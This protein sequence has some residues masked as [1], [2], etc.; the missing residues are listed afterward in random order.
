MTMPIDL[1]LV[2]HGE[3]EGNA[4]NARSRQ[5]DNRD[6]NELYLNRHSSKW[7]LTDRGREQAHL[8]GLWIKENIG[9]DFF[10]YYVSEYIRAMETAALLDLPGAKWYVDFYLRERD[11]G[12]LDLMTDESRR[13]KFAEELSRREMD[14]FYWCPPGGESMA[15]LCRRIDRIL[16]TMHRE[17]ADKK[18]IIVCHGE[19]MWAMLVRLTRMLQSRFKELDNSKHPFDHI[20]NCQVLHFTRKNPISGEISPYMDWFRSVCPSDLSLSR[21]D[22]EK[23]ERRKFSNQDLLSEVEQYERLVAR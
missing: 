1:V 6:F 16:G 4:A 2:R 8:A 18:V 23:I 12:M 7:R 5:G 22:W 21:N 19:V 15:Q 13:E 20:H 14:S 11:W 3:S 9:T 10:R 17:C